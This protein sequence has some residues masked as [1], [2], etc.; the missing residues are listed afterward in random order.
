MAVWF[1]AGGKRYLLRMNSYAGRIGTGRREDH[2]PRRGAVPVT[3][4]QIRPSDGVSNR[5]R[6][7][8]QGKGNAGLVPQGD[9][10]M[11]FSIDLVN[12]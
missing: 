11:S 8:L 3:T 6:L 9:Y 4:W 10:N 2:A 1:E 5:A 7:F 12:Q